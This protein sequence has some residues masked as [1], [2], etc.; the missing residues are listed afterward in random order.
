[1]KSDFIAKCEFIDSITIARLKK[2]ENAEPSINFT[3]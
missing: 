2:V 3:F 1:M